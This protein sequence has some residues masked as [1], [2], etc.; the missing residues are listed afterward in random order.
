[1][2]NP[3]IATPTTS[4]AYS[5]GFSANKLPSLMTKDNI[6]GTRCSFSHTIANTGGSDC[7]AQVTLQLNLAALRA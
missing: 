2:A 3:Q 1:V 6:A 5:E 7:I 4:T